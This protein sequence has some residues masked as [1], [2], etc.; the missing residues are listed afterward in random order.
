MVVPVKTITKFLRLYKKN[1][2]RNSVFSTFKTDAYG[3]VTFALQSRAGALG[4]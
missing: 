1:K 3:L 2:D 4:E